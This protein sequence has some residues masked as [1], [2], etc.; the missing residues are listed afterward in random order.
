MNTQQ[1]TENKEM[2]QID[3]VAKV[4][5][6]STSEFMEMHEKTLKKSSKDSAN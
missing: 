6:N 2:K 4:T 1:Y 3:T 5:G